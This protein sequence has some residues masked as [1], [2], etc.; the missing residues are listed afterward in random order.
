MSHLSSG[1]CRICHITKDELGELKCKHRFCRDCIS[2]WTELEN[3][4]PLCRSRFHIVR[5]PFSSNIYVGHRN[6][7]VPEDSEVLF[8]E[9]GFPL[10]EEEEER[11]EKELL[12]A[13]H[14]KCFVC[15]EANDPAHLLL[16]DHPNCYRAAHTYCLRPTLRRIPSDDWYCDRCETLAKYSYLSSSSPVSNHTRFVGQRCLPDHESIFSLS[17]E[18]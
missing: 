7:P 18:E 13:L 10:E 6:Q 11:K 2:K 8:I 15:D 12:Q 17:D 3:S 16:C 9:E 5:F 4:C 14:A 1:V